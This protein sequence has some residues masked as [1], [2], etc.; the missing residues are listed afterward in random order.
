M[1]VPKSLSM[2]KLVSGKL[3]GFEPRRDPQLLA[4]RVASCAHRM[5]HWR[6]GEVIRLL[7]RPIRFLSVLVF[8]WYLTGLCPAWA[9]EKPNFSTQVATRLVGN[10]TAGPYQ[11]EGRFIL[12]GTEK[13]KKDG[14]LL[15]GDR[16]YSIDYDRGTITFP[17]PLSPADT[18][19][20]NYEKLNLAL[21]RRYFH[22]E[23]VYRG[24]GHKRDEHSLSGTVSRGGPKERMREFFPQSGS[25]DLELSGSKT[26]SL[27][28]GSAQDMSLKQ[29]L[30]VSAKGKATKNMEVSVQLSD[31]NMP[32]TAQGST[33]RLEELDKVQ[34]LVNSP[35]F[36]G[37][38]GDF[39]LAP[40]GS[41]L[42]F[43]EKKLKGIMAEAGTGKSSASFALASSKG[44]YLTNRFQG[45]ENKQGPYQLQGKNGQINIMVLPGT[46]RVWVDGEKMGRGSDNDYIIDYSRGTI[47][48]TPRR[49]IT[50]D[51][52]ITV[53]F[54]YS[55]ES[56]K[57]DFYSGN[58]LAS[59]FGGKA[60][61][62]ATGIHE[63]DDESR[64]SSFSLSTEDKAILSQAG[65]DRFLASKDGANF[66]GEEMGDYDLAFDSSGN[67]YY[68]YVGSESGSYRV[69]FS[70][71]GEGEGSY[72]Y[73][74]GG[75]YRYVYPGDGDFLPATLL[76]LP[77]SHSLFDLSL[78]FYPAQALKTQIEW[79]R[80][81][82]DKN[83]FSKK[84]DEHNWG[85]AVSLKSTYQNADFQFLKP[86]FHRLELLAEYKLLKRDFAPF[87]RVDIVE[88]ERRWDLP[89]HALST[90]E[91]TYRFSG[92]ISPFESFLMDFDLG[93]LE[94]KEI[95]VSQRRSLGVEIFPAG[96][97]TAKGKSEKIKSQEVTPEDTKKRGEWTRNLIVVNNRFKSLST[98]LSWE[99]ERRGSSVSGSDEER[100]DF[101]Q[102]SGKISLGLSSVIKA[103]TQLCHREDD[104]L[105]EARASKSSSY[106]WRSQLSMR[107][108]KG[109][110]SSD[111]EFATRIKRFRRSSGE[112][113]RHD[114]LLGR[115]DFHPPSQL[116]TIRLYHSQNQIHSARRWD[117]YVEVEQGRGEYRYEDGEY[118]PDPE[119]DFVRLSEWAGETKSSLELNKSIRMIFSPYKVAPRSKERSFWSEVGRLFSTD[120]FINL[121]GRFVHDKPLSHYIFYPL[122]GLS[123]ESILSRNSTMRHD[124]YILPTSRPF[125]LRFRWEKGEDDDNLASDGGRRE[126]RLKQEV[127]LK[128]HVSSR[129]YIETRA[130][131][132]RVNSTRENEARDLIDGKSLAV[133]FTRRQARALDLKVFA[134][135]KRRDEKTGGVSVEFFS[136]TPELLLSLR[137]KG[138]FSA[139]FGWT[140]LRSVPEGKS[141]S[142][143]LSEGKKRG[144][145][146][147]WRCL[148]D[149][150]LNQHLTTSVTYRG[151]SIPDRKAKHTAHMELKAF[152]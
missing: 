54:E 43:Y 140:H 27:E 37:T 48:F 107:R 93:R 132:E 94:A 116:L 51:S 10:G 26:F 3:T 109:M 126:E 50:S 59:F 76:P 66:V 21:R 7:L 46:E 108:Y 152:F 35:H 8:L 104:K 29:G 30:W 89:G 148:F 73:A 19:L 31:Q 72:Q 112:D 74:G 101:D 138:R 69:L 42:F 38:L 150:K 62:K 60:E 9:A 61:F 18:L 40:S 147:Q 86:S 39:Y 142:Y 15:Q 144:E 129:H 135:Y 95:F 91:K 106:T 137:S 85:D 45:Q 141:L 145:N 79:A 58:L 2:R 124:L 88:K 11:L 128:S 64:P 34:L 32:A 14:L 24:D 131:K 55:T 136:L 98:S 115:I 52:R 49:L 77:E 57:R 139:R 12:E 68:Q 103:S 13:V 149:Y 6:G 17:F 22:R 122:S 41:D 119:G 33:K 146:Y 47:Q 20:V 71:V 63:A 87:G 102:L 1:S 130:G 121:R 99:Q 100:E 118:V 134:E 23:L 114:L 96:W 127:L 25:S 110:L 28:V 113:S 56:Y 44:E 70:R 92:I 83:T 90:D 78:S 80:S 133:G 84:E 16:D 36:S 125:S 4:S 67:L 105:R 5:R 82:R 120:S 97:I 123:G 143:L 65:N 81:K 75:V 117:T 111:L 151:E 53:D